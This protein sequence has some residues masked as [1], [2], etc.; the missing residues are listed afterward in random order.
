MT[1]HT[2]PGPVCFWT[3]VTPEGQTVECGRHA[4]FTVETTHGLLVHCC[5]EHLSQ[6]KGQSVRPFVVH[7]S[8]ASQY[9]PGDYVT[10]EA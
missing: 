6:A 3:I 7:D 5:L 8:H 1:P 10:I 4:P 9:H 2:K